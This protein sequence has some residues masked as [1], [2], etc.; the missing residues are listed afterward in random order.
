MRVSRTTSSLGK[1]LLPFFLQI[2]CVYQKKQYLCSHKSTIV[3]LAPHTMRNIIMKYDFNFF[4]DQLLLLQNQDYNQYK[5]VPLFDILINLLDE[6]YIYDYYEVD[7]SLFANNFVDYKVKRDRG[8]PYDYNQVVK[9]NKLETICHRFFNR[10]VR[11]KLLLFLQRN[12]KTLWPNWDNT[13]FIEKECARLISENIQQSRYDQYHGDFAEMPRTNYRHMLIDDKIFSEKTNLGKFME[14]LIYDKEEA[15]KKQI[16]K[17]KMRSLLAHGYWMPQHDKEF[18]DFNFMCYKFIESES[19][20]KFWLYRSKYNHFQFTFEDVYAI[21][22]GIDEESLTPEAVYQWLREYIDKHPDNHI[23]M[24][25]SAD[26]EECFAAVADIVWNIFYAFFK[27]CGSIENGVLHGIK[28]RDFDSMSYE[29]FINNYEYLKK[30]RKGIEIF[31]TSGNSNAQEPSIVNSE[32]TYCTYIIPNAPKP[33]DEIEL[34]LKRASQQSAQR[35]C[36]LLSNYEK[37]KYLDFRNES[38]P[39]IYSYFK[40]RY[41]LSYHLDTFQKAYRNAFY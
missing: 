21:E 12:I 33:R 28:H 13:E 18:Y 10:G 37:N 30:W 1:S 19:Y 23:N 3:Y 35:F 40:E 39:S 32:A 31:V 5:D 22:P 17:N 7:W 25:Y 34:D 16:E 2:V 15:R 8:M 24:L 41:R 4:H 29:D 20:K 36:N 6:E 11:I 38:V 14:Q 27:D 26:R 9:N